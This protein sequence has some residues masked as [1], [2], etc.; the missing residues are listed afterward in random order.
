[1]TPVVIEQNEN[2]ARENTSP[3]TDPKPKG[4]KVKAKRNEATAQANKK[5]II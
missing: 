4:V 5:Q 2:N 1:M 3:Q